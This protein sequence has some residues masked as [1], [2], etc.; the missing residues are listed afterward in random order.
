MPWSETNPM[1][2]RLKFVALAQEGLYSMTELCARFGISRDT[3]YKI[4]RRYEAEGIEGLTD[5]SRAPKHCPH[6]IPEPLQ[7]LLLDL[8][9][10]HPKWGPRTLLAYLRRHHPDL[11]LPAPSTVGDLFRRAGLVQPRPHQR[12]W[13]HP[14]RAQTQVHAPNQLWTTDFK[15]QF[16]TRDAQLCYPLTI[17]D[18]HTRFVLAVDGLSSTAHSGA[19]AVFERVFRTYGLPQAIRS[20]NG[21]P[22]A[23]KAV[24]GLSQLSVWW[25]QLGIQHQ[26]IEP[27]HPEQNGSHER[28][29]RTLKEATQW[30][31]A[32]D[33]P[34]QQARF[35][36]FRA[37]FN[38]ERPHQALGMQTP[39][40]LYGASEREMPE[41]IPAPE[42]PGHCEIR[43]VRGNGILYF[44]DRTIFLSELLIGQ[45]VALEEI[46]D[47]VWSIY[48]Y[49]LLLARLD[50]RTF[51]ISG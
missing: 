19:R 46:A 21:G 47:G 45:Q 30:P 15:G 51:E 2:E 17:A 14:G 23:T 8:R 49:G 22:F 25:T 4:R 48:F 20:D 36:H 7:A 40:S 10:E 12:T 28:M 35:D 5:R 34:E 32:A 6:R 44:R 41:R 43:Q 37:E 42:Y 27:G 33:G 13:T 38:D 29:H 26:R 24:S 18:A 1:N 16:R 31:P 3:G 9:R 11:V 39:G 50:E